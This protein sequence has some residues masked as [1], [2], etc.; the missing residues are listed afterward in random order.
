MFQPIIYDGLV[1]Q[2]YLSRYAVTFDVPGSRLV[3]A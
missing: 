1:G 3:L 2:E